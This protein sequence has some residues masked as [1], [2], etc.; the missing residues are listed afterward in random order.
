MPENTEDQESR[1]L[2]EIPKIFM[3]DLT[4]SLIEKCVSC[5]CNLLDPASDYLIEKALKTYTGFNAY[6]TIF[7]YAICMSCAADMQ[8]KISPES[9]LRINAYFQHNFKV[10][11]RRTKLQQ[12]EINVEGWL[13][14]CVV[15]GQHVSEL[16][17]CQLYAQCHGPFLVIQDFPYMISGTVLDELIDLLSA[18]TLDDLDNFKNEFVGGPSEFQ[19]L[20]KSGPKVFI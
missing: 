12:E 18:R 3:S 13:E 6:S 5:E 2:I 1:R 14:N 17:E 8:N 11:D 19:D 20:L 16:S 4:G 15:N 9:R 10:E 7:E